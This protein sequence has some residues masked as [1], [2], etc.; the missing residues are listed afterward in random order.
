MQVEGSWLLR[1]AQL[2][3]KFARR[4]AGN[5]VERLGELSRMMT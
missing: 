4:A 5:R 1:D 2:A 3:A